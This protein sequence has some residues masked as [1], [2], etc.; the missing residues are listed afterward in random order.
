MAATQADLARLDAILKD[1]PLVDELQ[2]AFNSATPLAEK[3]TQQLTLSGRK[4]IFP[5]SFG[6]NEGVYARADKATFGDSQ[7][8]QPFLA[9]ISAKFVYAIFEI[10]GPTMSATRD[11]PGAFEDALALQ[12]ENTLTGV[13]LDMARMILN[14]NGTN[15]LIATVDARTDAD[16]FT[17]K[18]PFGLT[19]KSSR[20]VRNLLRRNMPIDVKT[21]GG[22]AH[23]TNSQITSVTHSA[24]VTTLDVDPAE[25]ATVAAADEVFR[26]GNKN[27]EISGFFEAVQETGTYLSIAR[28]GNDGW[29]GV[30][31]DAAAGGA[32]AV[33]LDPDMLRDQMDEIM[34]VSGRT[35][36]LIVANYKQR[37]NIYNLFAPQI[38]YAPMV[39]PAGLR[40]E[41]LRFDDLPVLAE[42][43]FPPEHIGFVDT[44]TWYH[45]IDK[46]VEWI[47]GLNGTVLHFTL[48][49]DVF[50]AVLRTYRNLACF[51]PAANGYLFGLEE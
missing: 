30:V 27:N 51:Y 33:P 41:T 29:Q 40:E 8:D 17:V 49:A 44:G 22:V 31:T 14:K 23:V 3:I 32:A 46:D 5:V 6:V 45:A 21:T 43:F 18:N 48:T 36:T 12:L 10:S 25:V 4:G 19:Y 50:K 15:G 11:N 9:S 16:T 42:R 24:T 38:R 35:P 47:Q 2:I 13:K 34:E 1:R 39:L 26:A 20:P 7:V 37:R 28:A